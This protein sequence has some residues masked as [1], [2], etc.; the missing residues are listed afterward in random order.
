MIDA[1]DAILNRRAIRAFKADPLSDDQ[2][3]EIVRIAQKAPSWI[4][5]QTGRV[6]IVTGDKL[7][8]MRNHHQRLNEDPDIHTNSDVPFIPIADWDQ[9][10]QKNMTTRGATGPQIFGAD[11]WNQM[12]SRQ[13]ALLFNA[14]A[15]AYLTLPKGYAPW[16]LYDLGALGEAIMV[17]A[18]SL[19]IDSIPAFE[20]IKYPDQLRQALNVS[21]DYEFILGIGLGYADH[22]AQI[23]R[24]NAPRMDLNQVLTIIK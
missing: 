22:D 7:A 5:S 15:V 2:L 24:V 16:A 17:A 23:N 13:S 8:T 1:K 9:A 4:D 11:S 20:F 3:R 6:I 21:A 19:G 18:Q 12:K 14:P 10:S